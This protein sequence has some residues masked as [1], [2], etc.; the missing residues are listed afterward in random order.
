M[1]VTAY[2]YNG[3]T[4]IGHI[5]CKPNCIEKLFGKKETRKEYKKNENDK[6]KQE[7][8]FVWVNILSGKE[9]KQPLLDIA[10]KLGDF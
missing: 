7:G 2:G 1:K 4:K 6:C 5:V 8:K 10:V 9:T 3:N